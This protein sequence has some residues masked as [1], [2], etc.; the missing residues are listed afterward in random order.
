MVGFFGTQHDQVMHQAI[1]WEHRYPWVHK[2]ESS[3][4]ATF[5][6]E[7]PESSSYRQILSSNPNF[8]HFKFNPSRKAVMQVLG[9][10]DQIPRQV[11]EGYLD[12]L[13]SEG[14]RAT[15]KD[16]RYKS[17]AHNDWVYLPN[18]CKGWN[19][20]TS[21]HFQIKLRLLANHYNCAHPIFNLNGIL[22]SLDTELRSAIQTIVERYDE[23]AQTGEDGYT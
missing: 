6:L 7:L 10:L 19:R 14:W 4:R 11:H 15:L 13:E 8:E 22:H 1:D 21:D 17:A 18:A 20:S 12:M 9:D 3:Q 16:G 2:P 23:A 5:M